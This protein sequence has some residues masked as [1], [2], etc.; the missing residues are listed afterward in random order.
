MNLYCAFQRLKVALQGRVD[1]KNRTKQNEQNKI[2]AQ[3]K[4]EGGV[5]LGIGRGEEM[6][7]RRDWKMVRDSEVRISW[8]REFQ[9]LEAALEKALSPNVDTD[10]EI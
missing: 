6:V 1:Y 8:G 4:R 5:G 10:K 3:M 7:L 2:Q 9:S